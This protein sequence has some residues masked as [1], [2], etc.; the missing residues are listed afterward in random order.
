M[1]DDYHPGSPEAKLIAV[2]DDFLHKWLNKLEQSLRIHKW[3][4]AY[5]K[6]HPETKQGV[7]GANAKHGHANSIVSFTEHAARIMNCDKRTIERMVRVGALISPAVV[8][9][10][11]ELPKKLTENFSGDQKEQ[12]ALVNEPA[13][14]QLKI[15]KVLMG[16]YVSKL[17]KLQP[18]NSFTKAKLFLKHEANDGKFKALIDHPFIHGDFT[19][20]SVVDKIQD[21]T[22][23][24]IA[25]DMPYGKKWLHLLEPLF[26]LYV[27]KLTPNGHIVIMYGQD[28]TPWFWVTV[29][30]LFEQH[31][32]GME[33][34][35]EMAAVTPKG[36]VGSCKNHGL[37]IHHWKPLAV[38]SKKHKF[39]H[40]IN[41]TIFEDSASDAEIYAEAVIGNGKKEKKYGDWQQRVRDWQVVISRT[42][43]PGGLVIDVCCGTGTTCIAAHKTGRKT[44]GIEI[45][46]SQ[47]EI[48]KTRWAEE[49]LGQLRVISR[50]RTA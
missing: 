46:E 2:E 5:L 27:P 26:N 28:C 47:F 35:G 36:G 16:T 29:T 25:I 24:L 1:L 45:D 21:G 19:D 41:D 32:M 31:G 37:M 23:S 42:S 9:A 10:L 11:E 4:Q 17:Q 3:K 44:I 6:L 43:D 12:L 8:T 30:P 34:R 22:V 15:F 38:F 49:V 48:A 14:E 39:E 13:G 18:T 33:Y 7:A 50:K 40:A 20:Q